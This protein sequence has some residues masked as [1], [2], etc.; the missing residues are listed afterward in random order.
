MASPAQSLKAQGN[1]AFKQRDFGAAISLYTQAASAATEENDPVVLSESLHNRG[2]CK[3]KESRFA[4]ALADFRESVLTRPAYHKARLAAAAVLLDHLGDPAAAVS[5]L[6]QALADPN[7][8]MIPAISVKRDA[9]LL[10]LSQVSEARESTSP[11]D[12][13]VLPAPTPMPAELLRV[14]LTG[15]SCVSVGTPPAPRLQRFDIARLSAQ[16]AA[17]GTVEGA[18]YA[19]MP[20]TWWA[21]WSMHVGGF[22]EEADVAP[23][24]RILRKRNSLDFGVDDPDVIAH[25]PAVA[26]SAYASL[27]EP[28]ALRAMDCLAL[29]DLE[30]TAAAMAAADGLSD[31][32]QPRLHPEAQEV[33]DFV[34]VG[35]E[36]W[37]ALAAWHGTRGPPL[38]RVAVRVPPAPT[39]AGAE[40]GLRAAASPTAVVIDLRP[41][42]RR[43][44][45]PA[46]EAP[47]GDGAVA[48]ALSDVAA[49]TPALSDS[50]AAKVDEVASPFA[51]PPAVVASTPAVVAAAAPPP[52]PLPLVALSAADATAPATATPPKPVCSKCGASPADLKCSRCKASW[53]CSP[54][55]QKEHWPVHK[56]GCGPAAGAVAVVGGGAALALN[57][58][59]GLANLG[60]TCF[61]NSSLQALAATWPLSQVF[62]SGAWEKLLNRENKLGTGGRLAAAY[63]DLMRGLWRS[64]PGTR[65]VRGRPAASASLLLSAS[66]PVHAPFLLAASLPVHAPPGPW[67]LWTSSAPSR[68]S[69]TA[70][71]DSRS[72]TRRSCSTTSSTACTRR[73]GGGK[74]GWGGAHCVVGTAEPCMARVPRALHSCP[75]TTSAYACLPPPPV[76]GPELGARAYVRGG[77]GRERAARRRGRPPQLGQVPREEQQRRCVGWP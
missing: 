11:A 73:G 3:L 75:P 21:D 12:S 56:K 54:G 32:P 43:Y 20:A 52:P 6:Q 40:E 49:V 58:R 46:V 65:C 53:Y 70:S 77:R 45:A 34:V 1:A 31:L 14:R 50:A 7:C 57:G 16:Y 19:L 9:A 29:V 17:T 59:V 4:E 62:L 22:S 74:G 23:V 66:L 10:A 64:P 44:E 47:T 76:A 24:L 25:Y 2:Q 8:D 33:Q 30:G 55:C 27:S 13:I 39:G 15:A 63:A 69:R 35:L 37:R 28:E 71:R 72:T 5:L 42:L 61:M 51:T 26:A 48:P 36:V 38:I 60:N 41:E 68:A 67:R 18:E